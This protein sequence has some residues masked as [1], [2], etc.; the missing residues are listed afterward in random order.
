MFMVVKLVYLELNAEQ[1]RESALMMKP[2]TLNSIMLL[3]AAHFPNSSGMLGP[4][5]SSH[6]PMAT[7]ATGLVKFGSCTNHPMKMNK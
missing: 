5:N 2:P 3:L 4:S 1:K 7:L 6:L